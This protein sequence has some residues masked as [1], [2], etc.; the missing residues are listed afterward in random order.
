[1]TSVQPT[2]ESETMN[3]EETLARWRAE[4]KAVRE[5]LAEKAG[6]ARTEQLDGRSGLEALQA[7]LVLDVTCICM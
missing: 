5:R 6:C 2:V 3:P 7:I 1:M 4:E